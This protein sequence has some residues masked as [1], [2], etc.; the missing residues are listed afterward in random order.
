W[1][2]EAL[3]ETY[4]AR[5]SETKALR[6]A[7]ASGW[8]DEALAKLQDL[9]AL[10]TPQRD[11]VALRSE[12][13]G[14]I[15]GGGARP[16]PRP[17][18]HTTDAEGVRLRGHKTDV[19]SLSFS[20]DGTQ[21]ASSDTQ[22]L[23]LWSIPEARHLHGFTDRLAKPDQLFVTAAPWPCVRFRPGGGG[24]FATANWAGSA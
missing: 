12:A 8:R 7:G 22:H 19:W 20:P 5:F 2:D 3:S 10:P 11:L 24:S 9:V 1:R 21:L 4:R 15:G 14:C 18:P 23:R 13:V 16:P 6:L 17:P